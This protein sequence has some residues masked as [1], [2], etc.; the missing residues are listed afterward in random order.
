MSGSSYF[1]LPGASLQDFDAYL[2]LANRQ[3]VA[4]GT[5]DKGQ[6]VMQNRPRKVLLRAFGILSAACVVGFGLA[7]AGVQLAGSIGGAIGA[8]L[9][10]GSTVVLAFPPRSAA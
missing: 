10:I 5:L 7:V 8:V 2:R 9:G 4:S 6:S 1:V 3:V